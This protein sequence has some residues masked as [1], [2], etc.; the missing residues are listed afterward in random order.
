VPRGTG[1]VRGA[2]PRAE[3]VFGSLEMVLG[4][5]Q[6]EDVAGAVLLLRGLV[7]AHGV[8]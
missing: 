8:L 7:A 3:A 4:M 5:L 2:L 1:G 6:L